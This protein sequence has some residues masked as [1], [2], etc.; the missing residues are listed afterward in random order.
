[1]W[2]FMSFKLSEKGKQPLKVT[3]VKQE[4]KKFKSFPV[5]NNMDTTIHVTDCKFHKPR[6]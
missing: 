5:R 3:K 6:T 4:N 2:S 1:M